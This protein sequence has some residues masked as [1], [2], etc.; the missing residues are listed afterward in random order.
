M[1]KCVEVKAGQVFNSLTVID[2]VE[3]KIT[4]GGRKLRMMRCQC[5]CGAIITVPL[6]YLRDGH[7]KSC[8]KCIIRRKIEVKPGDR[9]HD[10]TVIKE[11]E[12]R[13]SK[14]GYKSRMVR[15]Q[16]KCGAI[17]DIDL[18]SISKGSSKRCRSCCHK[19]EIKA[20][21][22][23]GRWTVI[24]EVDR[25]AKGVQKVRVFRCRC[26]CGE[27]RDI[28]LES[29]TS[30]QSKECRKCCHKLKINIGQVFGE[31][32]VIK[33]IDPKILNNQEYRMFLC[34]CKCGSDEAVSLSG[35]NRGHSKRCRECGKKHRINKHKDSFREY[36]KSRG[37]NPDVP[38]TPRSRKE[39][40]I[41]AETVRGKIY[42]RDN[43]KCQVCFKPAK[44]V[45]HIIPWSACYKPEDEQLR[46]DPENCICLCEECH[47][48]AHGG[49]YNQAD[50]ID[51]E[52][53]EQLMTKA[54]EN[55]EKH[56][57]LMGGL[58]EEALKKVESIAQSYNDKLHA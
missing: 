16:C 36:R 3:R 5:K 39:R 14:N 48:K 51:S 17:K 21:Q 22:V 4:K 19:A 18:S 37:L 35:L 56:P 8:S 40:E 52:I 6:I 7:P 45:H 53:A 10:W 12:L 2:E 41:F 34:R 26:E 11:V 25:K 28:M 46:F 23:F 20:G 58:K 32:T 27:E 15:V 24:K 30:G 1:G 9:Y 13:I 33:E 50:R 44:A 43:S 55:T 49:A 54:I 31:L 38:I 57:E 42:G 47:L 29:L